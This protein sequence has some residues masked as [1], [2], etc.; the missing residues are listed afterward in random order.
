MQHMIQGQ[1]QPSPEDF[2]EFLKHMFQGQG[3]PSPEDSPEFLLETKIGTISVLLGEHD[4]TLAVNGIHVAN[5]DCDTQAQTMTLKTYNYEDSLDGPD[6]EQVIRPLGEKQAEG[7][8]SL[9]ECI[10]QLQEVYGFI[11]LDVATNTS[12][13]T[14]I[15]VKLLEDSSS[16]DSFQ[17]WHIPNKGNAMQA[18]Y[19][20]AH[21]I[22]SASTL[23]AGLKLFTSVC[24][25]TDR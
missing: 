21:P 24:E 8:K 23:E 2:P 7:T 19:N 22:L 16:N 18:L 3:Q 25:N 17:I 12:K 4:I 13:D 14:F 6:Y 11:T 5:L 10:Q 15:L 20:T 9:K 1:G